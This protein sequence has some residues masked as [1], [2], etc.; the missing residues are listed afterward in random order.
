MSRSSG[1]PLV[2]GFGAALLAAWGADDDSNPEP[3]KEFTGVRGDSR[4]SRVG[5]RGSAAAL[6]RAG[7]EPVAAVVPVSA[8]IALVAG[9]GACAGIAV[10]SGRTAGFETIAV[11]SGAGA[12]FLSPEFSCVSNATIANTRNPSTA[13]ATKA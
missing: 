3:G 5:I 9:A 1:L 13:A 7:A 10:V 8:V 12:A 11:G 4:G 2:T 6:G